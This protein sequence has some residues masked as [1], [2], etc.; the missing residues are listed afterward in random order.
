MRERPP[1][2]DPPRTLGIGLQESPTGRRFLVRVVTLFNFRRGLTGEVTLY[3][4]RRGLDPNP[5]NTPSTLSPQPST[6]NPQPPTL[7]PQPTTLDP[8]PSTLNSRPSTT[9]LDLCGRS[10]TCGS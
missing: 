3:D 7:N 5:E 6:L 2:S 8:Q 9:I 10:T 1:P 4:F